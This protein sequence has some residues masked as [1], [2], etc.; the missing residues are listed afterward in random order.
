MTHAAPTPE[1]TA[2]AQYLDGYT[3]AAH[4]TGSAWNGRD[5]NGYDSAE[6]IDNT[7]GHET[8][9]TIDQHTRARIWAEALQAYAELTRP[10]NG[11]LLAAYAEARAPQTDPHEGTV[12]HYIGHDAYLSAAHHGT[13]LWDRGIPEGTELHERLTTSAATLTLDTHTDTYYYEG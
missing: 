1:E 7:P 11:Q 9:D 3:Q 8:P 10:D 12:W 6:P 4:W 2:L 13:G 5:E